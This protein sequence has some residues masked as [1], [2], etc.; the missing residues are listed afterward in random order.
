MDKVLIAMS[1]GVDSSV[2]AWVLKNQGYECTGAMMKLFDGESGCCSYA[3]ADDA[4]AV[5]HKMG[6]PFYVFNF[7]QPFY[8]HVIERFVSAYQSGCTPNPC[9]DCN[10]FLKFD[11]FLKRAADIECRYIATGHY[12]QIEEAGGRFLL[13]KGADKTKDQSYALYTMTQDELSRTLFPLGGMAKAE[14][15]G[16]AEAQGFINANKPDSQDICFAPDG[17]YAGFIERHTG[18][19]SSRGAFTDIEGKVI[20]EHKGIIHYTVGQRRGLGLSA[21][22]PLYVCEVLPKTNT[23]V[24]GPNERLFGTVLTAEDINLIAAKR[25]DVPIRVKAKIRYRHE[26][27]PAMVWQTGDDALRVEFDEP[28]RAITKGQAVVLYDGDTVV[29]GGVIS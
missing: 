16:I 20:G 15:R 18:K 22:D 17:D 5:A 27:Q 26:E 28:Q 29:G 23:V 12:A 19:P 7:T 6:M 2:A 3:D 13:K 9:I 11:R 25:L 1:G 14:V 21:K 8:E 4:R 10:R 24:V